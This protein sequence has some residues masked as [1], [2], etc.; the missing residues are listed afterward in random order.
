ME[1]LVAD[2]RYRF[3][4]RMVIQHMERMQGLWK[5]RRRLNRSSRRHQHSLPDNRTVRTNTEYTLP[6]SL[7][8]VELL[9]G[10]EAPTQCAKRRRCLGDE[11]VD[12]GV[13][14][15]GVVYIWLRQGIETRC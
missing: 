14:G 8:E 1:V 3:T 5:T 2:T 13:R 4:C 9:I 10:K 15:Q 11:L 12:V 6:L 7:L